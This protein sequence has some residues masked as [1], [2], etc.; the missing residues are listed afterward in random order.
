MGAPSGSLYHT[1]QVR[2]HLAEESPPEPSFSSF[3][4][5][6]GDSG[7]PDYDDADGDFVGV[8]V[9]VVSIEGKELYAR[10]DNYGVAEAMESYFLN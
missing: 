7:P 9:P 5:V 2:G 6:F 1:W 3:N 4:S 8:N 10:V